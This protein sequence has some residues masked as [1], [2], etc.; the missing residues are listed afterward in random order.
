ML[1]LLR[2]SNYA[3]I[4]FLE[5]N[6]EEGLTIITGETG[7]GKSIIMGALSLLLGQRF[8]AKIIRNNEKKSVIEACFRVTGYN[9]ENIFADKI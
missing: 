4:D 9:L 2:I 3:L 5:I 1:K 8:D 6:L 7:A